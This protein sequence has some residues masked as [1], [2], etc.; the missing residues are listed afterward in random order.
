MCMNDVY[1]DE[2]KTNITI[3]LTLTSKMWPLIYVIV[4]SMDIHSKT[5]M[6]ASQILEVDPPQ[7]V[8]VFIDIPLYVT[9]DHEI[10]F[11]IKAKNNCYVGIEASDNRVF[12]LGAHG[13]NDFNEDYLNYIRLILIGY[14]PD[15][16]TMEHGIVKSGL[17]VLSNAHRTSNIHLK[18]IKIMRPVKDYNIT[19]ISPFK[20]DRDNPEGEIIKYVCCDVPQITPEMEDVWL[21]KSIKNTNSEWSTWK[22]TV[23]NTANNWRISAFAIHSE[24]GLH[25]LSPKPFVKVTSFSTL[26][27][28]LRVPYSIRLE[29]ALELHFLCSNWFSTGQKVYVDIYP[30][31]QFE[32]VNRH[33]TVIPNVQRGLFIPSNTTEKF[34]FYIRALR[35]GTIKLKFVIR[36]HIEQHKLNLDI[37]V[38]KNISLSTHEVTYY[39]EL[40]SRQ[41]DSN[42][43][44][45]FPHIPNKDGVTCFASG[46]VIA[47]M[48]KR[49]IN[50]FDETDNTEQLISKLFSIYYLWNY[51]VNMTVISPSYKN[52]L[53]DQ[54]SCG[55]QS[56]MRLRKANGGYRNNISPQVTCAPKWLTTYVIRLLY[57]LENYPAIILNTSLIEGT[58]N[59]LMKNRGED[60]HFRENCYTQSRRNLTFLELNIEII[61]VLQFSNRLIYLH[62]IQEW[63]N[64]MMETKFEY[65]SEAKRGL[66]PVKWQLPSE[67]DNW[68][69]YRREL[70]TAGRILSTELSL[71]SINQKDLIFEWLVSQI[72][73]TSQH[74]YCYECSIA[75]EAFFGYLNYRGYVE[76]NLTVWIWVN[77]TKMDRF[78]INADNQWEELSILLYPTENFVRF[79]VKGKGLIFLRCTYNYVAEPAKLQLYHTT[80]NFISKTQIKFCVQRFLRIRKY[81]AGTNIEIVLPSGYVLGDGTVPALMTRKLIIQANSINQKSKLF[82]TMDQLPPGNLYCYNFTA[83]PYHRVLNLQNATMTTYDIN[84]QLRSRVVTFNKFKESVPS[85]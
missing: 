9:P 36:S 75:E 2:S 44:L 55:Y 17:V 81:Y 34:T 32:L 21:F 85:V 40:E 42:A 6:L 31:N 62:D 19:H 79:R 60:G 77:S 12:N 80:I 7:N 27:Y 45:Y 54:L 66:N 35:P 43:K 78:Y 13:N 71:P 56:L 61:K 84:E 25:Y 18:R 73:D 59:F 28:S 49:K 29:E 26:H 65:Y 39:R 37:E 46:Q 57:Q 48:L 8:G 16:L 4:Y 52:Y 58:E 64:W 20:A 51:V 67:L 24:T 74:V 53:V 69:L 72:A 10:Q 82:L 70:E 47:H 63:M 30:N 11:S 41:Y 83:L 5:L 14:R 3:S 22:A 76:S 33:L 15:I 1:P 38:L 68:V 23:P 50:V